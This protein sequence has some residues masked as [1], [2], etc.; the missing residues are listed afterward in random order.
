MI[1]NSGF[2]NVMTTRV[3]GFKTVSSISV[4]FAAQF[5]ILVAIY[6][7]LTAAL[8]LI[9]LSGL[10]LTMGFVVSLVATLIISL[11]QVYRK[12]QKFIQ[13]NQYQ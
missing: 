11:W 6:A 5:L 7:V 12:K 8:W 3:S 9:G 4:L 10:D 2:L 13:N 1:K